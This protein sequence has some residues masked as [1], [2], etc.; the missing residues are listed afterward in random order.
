MDAVP[1]QRSF[2]GT[3]PLGPLSTY[4]VGRNRFSERVK[5]RVQNDFFMV[6]VGFTDP[7]TGAVITSGAFTNPGIIP[8][9]WAL[10]YCG[11]Q[12]TSGGSPTLIGGLFYR[13]DYVC[14][15]LLVAANVGA[16]WHST[17]SATEY[18]AMIL[19]ATTNG[20]GATASYQRIDTATYPVASV[21][22]NLAIPPASANY[23][24]YPSPHSTY[25]GQIIAENS[26]IER[27]QRSGNIWVRKTKY[28]LAQ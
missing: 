21:N 20:W 23:G 22:C 13:V 8:E 10:A 17:P 12:L 27:W 4:Q 9:V 24:A 6:G 3:A 11:Q 28:V 18:A 15:P 7:I 16:M 25:G 19:D 2:I 26:T 14:D 5:C 1:G